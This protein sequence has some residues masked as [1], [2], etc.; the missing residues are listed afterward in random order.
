MPYSAAV[1]T[2]G[3]G[4]DGGANGG[5]IVSVGAGSPIER[6]NVSKPAGSATM[7]YRASG[8]LT[9]K[10]WGRSRGPY[11]NEPAGASI[12]LPSTQR[13]SSPSRRDETRQRIVDA[14]I[15][16]H[17]TLGPAA[18]TVSE[19]AERAGVGR[20]TV[21]R[22]FPDEPTLSRACSGQYFERNQ[23]PDPDRSRAIDDARERLRAALRETYAYHRSTEA[24]MTRVL[25]DARDHSA[26][27]PYH[28]LWRDATDVL[29]EPWRVRGRRRVLLRAG[30]A[31]ALS[32]D[33]WRTLVQEQALTDEQAVE[34]M[35]RLRSG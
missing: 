22:H 26:T 21:Y 20:V 30:I 12:V 10:V 28:E 31:L 11:T 24:M 27:A 29:V 4:S 5:G 18:T 35:L 19:I 25:A 1:A 3:P 33:T 8:E 17:Q 9:T 7:R 32:F 6:T 13:A 23:P 34:L 2:S 15:E 16:L 14:T